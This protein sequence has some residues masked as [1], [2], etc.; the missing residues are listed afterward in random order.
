MI[1]V[2]GSRKA[3]ADAAK[4]ALALRMLSMNLKAPK[5]ARA[6]SGTQT[7]PARARFGTFGSFIGFAGV[8][9]K[10]LTDWAAEPGAGVSPVLNIGIAIIPLAFL[11]ALTGSLARPFGGKLADRFGGAKVTVVAFSLMVLGALGV[12]MVLS[13]PVAERSFWVFLLIF[14]GIF[15]ATGIG[16]GST[17]R[18]IPSIFAARGGVADAHNKG[19]DIS[20]QRKTSAA[21]GIISA[22]G[23]YGGFIIP[24]VLGAAKTGP[25]QSYT[26]AVWGFI[27]AYLLFIAITAFFYLRR[28]A[29]T[30]GQRI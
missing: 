2:C 21:I 22:I 5:I 8:F 11:G 1:H 17:Y 13:Q 6:M 18:M 7:Q 23:A 4:S 30:T 28:G 20:V 29:G 19:G 3:E 26:P 24:Q 27:A 25:A 15:A 16:N 12:I 9:P 14:L 10:I